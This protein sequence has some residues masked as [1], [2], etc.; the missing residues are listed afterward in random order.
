M[1]CTGLKWIKFIGTISAE[2]FHSSDMKSVK[3]ITATAALKWNHP[4]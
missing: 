4:Y 2:L 1:C 3:G